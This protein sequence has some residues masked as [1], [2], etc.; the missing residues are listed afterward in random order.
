MHS[1]QCEFPTR[2]ID[3]W[4]SARDLCRS[5]WLVNTSFMDDA[6]LG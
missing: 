6:G 3:G 1:D 4:T 5:L 2:V